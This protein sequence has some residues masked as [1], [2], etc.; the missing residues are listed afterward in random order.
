M[1]HGQLGFPNTCL[2]AL[3]T[4]DPFIDWPDIREMDESDHA[5]IYKYSLWV[6]GGVPDE[7]LESVPGGYRHTTMGDATEFT[8]EG[9]TK[10]TVLDAIRRI[11]E[12]RT[13]KT[14]R[15]MAFGDSGNDIPM[16]LAADIGVAM[17]NGTDAA[18]EAADYVCAPILEDGLLH[19]F[20]H[21]GLA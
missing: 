12:T 16:L 14:W 9:H 7:V 13:G 8:Q 20:E 21:F 2:V 10:A 15:T 1:D 5:Q 4:N 19:A 11:V 18:K 17:G 3:R 6:T